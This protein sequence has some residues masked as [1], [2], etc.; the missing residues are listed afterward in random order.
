MNEPKI[1]MNKPRVNKEE[2]RTAFDEQM[3]LAMAISASLDST[4]EY[5]FK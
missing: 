5:V 2:P 3:K 4:E 1:V